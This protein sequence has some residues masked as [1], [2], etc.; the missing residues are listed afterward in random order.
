MKRDE[1]QKSDIIRTFALNQIAS[2][3]TMFRGKHLEA[4]VLTDIIAFLV[5]LNYFSKGAYS[6]DI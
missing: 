4:Q 2:I 3:P 5:K 1:R 6:E